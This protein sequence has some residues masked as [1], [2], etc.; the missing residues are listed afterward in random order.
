MYVFP[1]VGHDGFSQRDEVFVGAVLEG[2]L[3]R[4]RGVA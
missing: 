2:V 1:E 4:I 3:L